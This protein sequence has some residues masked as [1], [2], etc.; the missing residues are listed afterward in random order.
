MQLLQRLLL[1][2]ENGRPAHR[3]PAPRQTGLPTRC[4]KGLFGPRWGRYMMALRAQS[5]SGPA[6]RFTTV[7]LRVG[8]C[9]QK[10]SRADWTPSGGTL[11]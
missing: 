8:A 9:P 3:R 2:R 1:G 4:E 5:C 7:T 10:T 11:T 6:R